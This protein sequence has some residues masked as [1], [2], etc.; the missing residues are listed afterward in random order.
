MHLSDDRCGSGFQLW[1][2]WFTRFRYGVRNVVL[3]SVW[4]G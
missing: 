3:V 2:L 1:P 4:Y